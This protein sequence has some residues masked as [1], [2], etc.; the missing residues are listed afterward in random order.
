MAYPMMLTAARRKAAA[1]QQIAMKPS[2]PPKPTATAVLERAW[3]SP[4]L[5][6][7]RAVTHP[8]ANGFIGNAAFRLAGFGG[9]VI[10][11]CPVRVRGG[12]FLVRLPS[13]PVLDAEGKRALIGGRPLYLPCV[14]LPKPLEDAF[15]RAA[16]AELTQ[17]RPELL[18]PAPQPTGKT[19]ELV[20]AAAQ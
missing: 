10:A 13:R 3:G 12:G 19:P 9:L 11:E 17:K 8:N 20:E 1:K 6:G 15:L 4:E 5:E 7:F 16:A 18:A 2:K 14:I